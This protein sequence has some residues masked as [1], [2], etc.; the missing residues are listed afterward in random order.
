MFI[1]LL[2]ASWFF[3]VG[4]A[5]AQEC[6]PAAAEREIATRFAAR[7][8]AAEGVC[9]TANV[10]IEML[11]FAKKSYSACLRGQSLAEVI[12]ELD[13]VID[14]ARQAKLDVGGC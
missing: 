14:Q 3:A 7:I 1:R 2:C 5:N 13:R 11:E 12:A 9:Q 6:D 4:A 8:A 10:Q